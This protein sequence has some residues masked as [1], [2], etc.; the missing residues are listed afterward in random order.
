MFYARLLKRRKEMPSAHSL[1]QFHVGVDFSR[2][3]EF[4]RV[5]PLAPDWPE[6]SRNCCFELWFGSFIVCL[7]VCLFFVFGSSGR[8]G[9]NDAVGEFGGGRRFGDAPEQ[10][11]DGVQLVVGRPHGGAQLPRRQEDRLRQ[12]WRTPTR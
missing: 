7:F 3:T 8:S 11:V 1:I 2:F 9:R 6:R 12:L 4:Y 5:S 10:L